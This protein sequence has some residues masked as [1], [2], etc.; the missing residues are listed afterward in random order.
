MAQI[1]RLLGLAIAEFARRLRPTIGSI[2]RY[3]I[4]TARAR[5][6]KAVRGWG[7]ARVLVTLEAPGDQ[8]VDRAVVLRAATGL[9]EG[10]YADWRIGV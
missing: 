1:E 2:F 5:R 6:V 4:A 8:Q 10:L 7:M 9:I 3:A